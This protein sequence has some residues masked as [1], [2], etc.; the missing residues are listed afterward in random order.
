MFKE[1]KAHFKSMRPTKPELILYFRVHTKKLQPFLRT[2]QGPHS[3]FKDY[4]QLYQESN[5]TEV[6]QCMSQIHSNRTS[7]LELFAPPTSL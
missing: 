3:I 2:F 6:K 7:R 1:A 5:F 4:L